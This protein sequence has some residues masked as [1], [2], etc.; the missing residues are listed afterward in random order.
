M[1]PDAPPPADADRFL[2]AREAQ[3]VALLED[4]VEM[5]GDLI[6][7]HG[8]ARVADIAQRMGVAH[9]TATKA[10]SRLKREGLAVSR[11]YR[12]VFLTED[13]AA[14]AE[15][16]RQRHRVVVDMLVAVGVPR[17]AAELDAE[18]IEHHVSDTTLHAFERYLTR[19]G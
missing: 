8:E 19:S 11:P 17:E 7:E 14:L 16:V 2:R 12:G 1:P 9:P 4:Y 15:R 18:G 13:G 10:V 5:I 6:A 3:A